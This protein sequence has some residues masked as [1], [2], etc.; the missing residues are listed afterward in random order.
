[1][2]MHHEDDPTTLDTTP[3]T[4]WRDQ[5]IE[6]DLPGVGPITACADPRLLRD[7]ADDADDD[8]AHVAH[9]AGAT[10]AA[11]AAGAA[12][13]ADEIAFRRREPTTPPSGEI[14]RSTLQA[15]PPLEL[16][17]TWL[18]LPALGPVLP[19]LTPDGMVV[20]DVSGR[21]SPFEV[22]VRPMG[23][24]ARPSPEGALAGAPVEG[25][26]RPPQPSARTW[27]RRPAVAGALRRRGGPV[28][29]GALVGTRRDWFEPAAAARE[30]LLAPHPDQALERALLIAVEHGQVAVLRIG[31]AGLDVIPTG[32]D[33]RVPALEG[34]ELQ[35][36]RRPAQCP[37][38]GRDGEGPCRPHGGPWIRASQQA[39]VEWEARRSQA[40]AVQDCGVCFGEALPPEPDQPQVPR[41]APR[42]AVVEISRLHLRGGEMVRIDPIA[43]PRRRR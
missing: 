34:M 30:D 21:E 31:P 15:R 14:V 18:V 26:P 6:L 5:L 11:D 33:P 24:P 37:L 35:V 13:A 38:H 4:T 19:T 22:R 20:A 25:R 16:E 40:L 10:G 43:P 7:D 29:L 42:T 32:S 12:H 9:A 2:V 3:A 39:Q 1:M 17:H 41:L 27:F 36:T 28:A 8:A 23:S